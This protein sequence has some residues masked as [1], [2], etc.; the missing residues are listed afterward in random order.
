MFPGKTR[1]GGAGDKDNNGKLADLF[2]LQTVECDKHK[3]QS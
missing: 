1:R 3:T 2:G